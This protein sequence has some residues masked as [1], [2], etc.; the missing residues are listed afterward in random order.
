MSDDY[1]RFVEPI[2][3]SVSIYDGG[4]IFLQGF[5]DA[6]E[7]QKVLFAT[8]WTQSE[9]MNGGLGQFF[10]NST[11]VLAPEAVE[12][13]KKLGMPK[14]ASILSEAMKF[15]GE[16]YPRE[17]AIRNNMLDCFYEKCGQE[18]IPMLEQ[19]DAMAIEIEEENGGFWDAANIYANQDN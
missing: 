1:W 7:K 10:S 9:I 15:F 12:G 14:C 5:N 8:H 19:E 2:W 3:D 13:F 16:N 17:R 11:G 4:D 18:S 6:T